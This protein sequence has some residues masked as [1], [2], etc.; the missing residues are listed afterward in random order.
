LVVTRGLERPE[1]RTVSFTT[2]N[3]VVCAEITTGQAG[4]H[5]DAAA[6]SAG[7]VSIDD[8]V[9]LRPNDLDS[10][11]HDY[12]RS[13]RI[14]AGQHVL[15]SII[16]GMPGTL[17]E[18]KLFAGT[19][20]P[21]PP[22][23]TGDTGD[24]CV[25]WGYTPGG[26]ACMP[27]ILYQEISTH[28]TTDIERHCAACIT[29]HECPFHWAGWPDCTNL[30]DEHS[31]GPWQI[32]FLVQTMS[33]PMYYTM[34]RPYD[35]GDPTT[36]ISEVNAM[37]PVLATAWASNRYQYNMSHGHWGWHD[38]ST[39]SNTMANCYSICNMSGH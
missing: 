39:A 26:G 29:D 10:H 9:M 12:H 13:V 37:D 6:A 31:L 7:G 2:P 5:Q 19:S 17:I 32:N 16:A 14:G 34:G 3:D 33:G 25:P 35:D 30:T 22:I 4:T 23:P 21:P 8:V 15:H 27:E 20:P 38:W 36:A 11:Y 28:W 24:R 18:V 1:E